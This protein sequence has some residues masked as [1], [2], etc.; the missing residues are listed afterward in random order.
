PVFGVGEHEGM[1][2]YVMQFI[3]GLG[4]DDVM[5]ELK[6]MQAGG[7]VPGAPTTGEL[8]VAR[9]DVSAA[10]VVRSLM[11]GDY[12]HT[13]AFEDEE[14]SPAPEEGKA[15][16]GASVPSSPSTSGGR[17]S[18]SFALSSSS[19]V[20]P[21]QGAAPDQTGAKKQTFW[22]A[23]ARIGVQVAGALEYAHKQGI[24]HRDIKPS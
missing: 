1:P 2:Y 17:L 20:L 3:Q 4:L 13:A 15:S 18:D 12:Q 22:Q 5:E 11:T 7:P 9:K 10:D 14:G 23:V 24:V 8:R 21:G 16:P 6:R 19:V